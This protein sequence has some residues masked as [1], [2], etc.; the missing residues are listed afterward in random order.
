MLW[1]VGVRR[2]T[3]AQLQ[4]RTDPVSGASI[5]CARSR[6]LQLMQGPRDSAARIDRPT[7]GEQRARAVDVLQ[8]DGDAA[9]K[10]FDALD[11]IRGVL[12][13]LS[14]GSWHARACRAAAVRRAAAAPTRPAG[15]WA[16]V[17]LARD[18][19]RIFVPG[20]N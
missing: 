19:A 1:G 11:H 3:S 13:R 7:D 12:C 10:E 20:I 9:I 18:S 15:G 5:A 6:Q 16:W 4:L 2:E 14:H 8:D 17:L